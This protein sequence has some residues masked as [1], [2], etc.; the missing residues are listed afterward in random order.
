MKQGWKRIF[1]PRVPRMGRV[2]QIERLFGRK[3]Y[4]DISPRGLAHNFC[5][6][7]C[8]H[9]VVKAVTT[10]VFPSNQDAYH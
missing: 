7:A 9:D 5:F 10:R 3:Q 4:L 8:P 2:T 1:F 6:P